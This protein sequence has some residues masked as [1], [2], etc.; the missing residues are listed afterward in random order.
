M[1]DEN[2]DKPGPPMPPLTRIRMLSLAALILAS[3]I[4]APASAAPRDQ[5]RGEEGRRSELDPECRAYVKKIFS[6]IKSWW[7]LPANRGR[8]SYE[9]NE[10]KAVKVRVRI[11][12][13]GRLQGVE[14]VQSSG[15]TPYDEAA[16]YAVRHAAPFPR[17]TCPQ[18]DRFSTEGIV[19][20]FRPAK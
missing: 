11:D 13:D 18:A 5:G 17:P 12:L 6:R 8:A 10:L 15:G 3:A 4:E 7:R 2:K 1:S 14:I 20:G 19:F 9:W 16:L